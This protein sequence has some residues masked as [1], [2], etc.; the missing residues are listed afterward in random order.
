MDINWA[1]YFLR[2]AAK[3]QKEIDDALS[4]QEKIDIV[5]AKIEEGM[6]RIR[7][8]AST[9]ASQM[10][11]IDKNKPLNTDMNAERWAKEFVEL[12]GGDEDL[13]RSWFANALMCGWDNHYLTTDEYK[14]S[15][16]RALNQE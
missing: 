1:A 3:D 6:E 10:A 9:P 13:M 12:H 8:I 2:K 5:D 14:K 4:I 15:I 7:K 16:E 11:L